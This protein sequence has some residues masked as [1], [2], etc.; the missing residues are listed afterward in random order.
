MTNSTRYFKNVW[1]STIINGSVYVCSHGRESKKTVVLPYFSNE[2]FGPWCTI[3]VQKVMQKWRRF[4]EWLNEDLPTLA[5]SIVDNSPF[6][7]G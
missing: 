3:E 4:F 7:D 2:L 5:A 6:R 1:T